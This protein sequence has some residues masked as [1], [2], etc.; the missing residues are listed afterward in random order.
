MEMNNTAKHANSHLAIMGK[1]GV[2]KTQF[3]LKSLAD[4]RA[5]SSFQTNFIYFER[6]NMVRKAEGAEGRK[7]GDR[8]VAKSD[9]NPWRA[10]LPLRYGW[11]GCA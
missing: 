10:S 11:R 6:L 4:I 2:G 5:Q 7:R 1:P 8:P 9:V 3:L